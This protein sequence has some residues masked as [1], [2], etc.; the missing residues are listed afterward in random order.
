MQ[1]KKVILRGEISLTP[2]HR[3]DV[4]VRHSRR[5]NM[6]HVYVCVCIS[7][8]I[9]LCVHNVCMYVCMYVLV[10]AWAE[11]IMVISSPHP[12][13]QPEDKDYLWP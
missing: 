1:D 8:C 4:L 7:V 2:S 13:A 3:G 10:I 9:T 12:R 11:D 6:V 5:W